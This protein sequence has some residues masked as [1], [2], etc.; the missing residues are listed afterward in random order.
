[1]KIRSRDD[2][3]ASLI[4]ALLVVTVVAITAGSLVTVGGSS[5]L[6]TVKLREVAGT[7]YAAD[8]GAQYAIS[9]LSKNTFTN[10][11]SSTGCFGTDSSSRPINSLTLPNFYKKTG[12]Q[13][14][15]SSVYVDCSPVSGSGAFGSGL[16]VPV[17]TKNSL[18]TALILL[19]Q[20]EQNSSCATGLHSLCAK[21]NG[22]GGTFRIQGGANTNSDIDPVTGPLSVLGD[23]NATA[24]P[25]T[26]ATGTKTC[27]VSGAAVDPG[28][29]P[30][31]ANSDLLN[32]AVMPYQDPSKATCSGGVK[33][34][35]PGYYDDAFALS[36]ATDA[37]AKGSCG[38]FWFKP[39]T[40]YFD[41]HNNSADPTAN[42]D[43]GVA[44][45]SGDV[46]TVNSN[47]SKNAV[48]VGGTPVDAN[49]AVLS[50]LPSSP[51]LPGAC[52]NP[53]DSTTTQGVQFV[54]GGDS[55]FY[56][57][58]FTSMELCSS[59]RSDRPQIALFGVPSGLASVTSGTYA[60]GGCS[61]APAASTCTATQLKANDGISTT[62]TASPPKKGS[63][64]NTLTATGFSGPVA[65]SMLSVGASASLHLKVWHQEASNFSAPVLTISI[66]GTPTPVLTRTLA[67]RTT[68]G[69]DDVDLSSIASKIAPLVHSGTL[70]TSFS[71]SI[72]ESASGASATS[73]VDS[74]QLL[75]NYYA[76]TL[77]GQTTGTIPG[78]CLAAAG[79]SG[80]A[81]ISDPTGSS[82]KGVFY[83]EGAT[84]APK[85]WINID[86]G[87]VS[88]TAFRFG[89][90]ARGLT[91]FE[92]GSL[93][94][95]GPVVS[96]PT[97]SPGWGTNVTM[98]DLKV[99]VCAQQATCSPT[100]PAAH[101][102]LTT[103]VKV[104]DGVHKAPIAGQ[105]QIN[106]LSWAEQR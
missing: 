63:V 89:L 38:T 70:G 50:A 42:P 2:A 3:G 73:S 39:G 7:A 18:G 27:T 103:R 79:G 59:Y 24:C 100:D 65:G 17:T 66:A 4:L 88:A 80:C 6:T 31:I 11:G 23:V 85:A 94:F 21:P 69:V 35:S 90:V 57:A 32:P 53:L 34:F 47:N 10:D 37:T 75:A 51:S 8:G 48:L 104:T 72:A 101:L 55:Q 76:P 77:R 1:M 105:R 91:A 5:F 20:G 25:N 97:P 96:I 60:S 13:T 9:L 61:W 102:T 45:T 62:W 14:A 98:V 83:I 99:Y 40:Y 82:Y 86:L 84:Y 46:W 12:T 106:V 93:L 67:A 71:V 15:D 41:F 28:L 36:A 95:S 92:P 49:G 56:L 30:D 19:G 22:P 44:T 54:F 58:N 87:G 68:A 33:T 16:G 64:A 74:I 81:W 43:A 78:N 52:Q 29:S 26:I